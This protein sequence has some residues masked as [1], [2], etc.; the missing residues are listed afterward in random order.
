M[1]IIQRPGAACGNNGCLRQQPD[2][3][4][5]CDSK[6]GRAYH[7]ASAGEQ[8]R[9]H[10]FLEHLDIGA[11]DGRAHR[12]PHRYPD[13]GTRDCARCPMAA[14][15]KGRTL[16]DTLL[17]AAEDVPERLERHGGVLRIADESAHQRR[18]VQV[19]APPHHVFGKILGA[20]AG[21][22]VG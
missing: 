10:G 20:V 18:I 21:S 1:R 13:R 5:R 9:T 19:F 22:L 14:G 8:F 6:R 15:R 3:L 7:F 2:R 17:V 12:M 4:A 16:E 11:G